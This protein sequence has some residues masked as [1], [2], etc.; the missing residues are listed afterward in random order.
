MRQCDIIKQEA[1]SAKTDLE[2]FLTV[3]FQTFLKVF[4]TKNCNHSVIV[5]DNLTIPTAMSS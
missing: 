3:H 4:L 2:F 1:K 5:K